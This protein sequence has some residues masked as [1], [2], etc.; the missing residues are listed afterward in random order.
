M[1][2]RLIFGFDEQHL[3]L[4]CELR[5]LVGPLAWEWCWG[6]AFLL[7]VFAY[8]CLRSFAKCC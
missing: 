1:H 8:S 6:H 3:D 5:S 4:L 2:G 7:N